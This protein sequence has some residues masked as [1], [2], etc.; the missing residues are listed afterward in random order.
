[1]KACLP[2]DA[3]FF[4]SQTFHPDASDRDDKPLKMSPLNVNLNLDGMENVLFRVCGGFRVLRPRRESMSIFHNLV[5]ACGISL[6][7]EP[8]YLYSFHSAQTGSMSHLAAT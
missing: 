2:A 7:L 8:L 1:M 3:D 5:L 4:I 6:P